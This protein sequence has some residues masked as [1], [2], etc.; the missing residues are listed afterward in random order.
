MATAIH[1]GE[2]ELVFKYRSPG[3]ILG[4]IISITAIAICMY[5]TIKKKCVSNK[6]RI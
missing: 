2:H 5:F 3:L 6:V 4:T 1:P